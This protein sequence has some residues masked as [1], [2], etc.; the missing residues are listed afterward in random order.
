MQQ[1]NC[2]TKAGGRAGSR[3]ASV[4]TVLALM[5]LAATGAWA[6]TETYTVRMKKGTKD[7]PH[8]AAFPVHAPAPQTEQM[9]M[10]I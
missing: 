2:K 4:L 5:L 1:N 7:S 10:A 9:D 8:R 6:Q 3:L